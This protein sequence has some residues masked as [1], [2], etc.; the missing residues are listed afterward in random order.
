MRLWVSKGRDEFSLWPDEPA[1]LAMARFLG[2]GVPWT[3]HDHSTWQPGYATL[4]SPVHWFTDDPVVVHHAALALNAL[5]GGVAAAVLVVLARRL[6]PLGPW[7]GAAVAGMVA[8]TPAVLFPTVLVWSESL[9]AVCFLLAVVALLRY[10]ETPT[11]GRGAWAGIVSAAAFGTHSRMLPLAVVTIGVAVVLAVRRE[12]SRRSAAA[13]VALTAAAMVA[14]KLYTG[15]IVDRLWDEPS[16]TNSLGGALSHVAGAPVSTVLA[17]AGQTWYLV[18]STVGLVV[19]GSF[20]VVRAVRGREEAIGP[21]APVERAGLRRRDS[22]VLLAIAVLGVA[23]SVLFMADR[24]RPDQVV[25]GR[26]N[27]VV[28]QPVVVIGLAV[29]VTTTS[30]RRIVVG[31]VTTG[32]LGAVCAAMLVVWR[33]DA[34]DAGA[35]IEPMILGLQPFAG[36]AD[37]I[38][39]VRITVLSTLATAVLA[40]AAILGVRLGRPAVVLAVAAGLIVVAGVRTADVINSGW[41]GRGDLERGG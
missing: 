26:Y 23:P 11:V 32:A 7:S 2:G 21:L 13:V 40:S 12:T 3:M 36:S 29:L 39:V 41:H 15:W 27:D 31:A 6:T 28:V 20:V 14:V 35:G 18:V 33:R 25:Y 38:E 1:Q 37:A 22:I 19:Y 9:V 30:I 16:S 24:Y 34:L 17:L 4:L 8:L 5:L 10:A